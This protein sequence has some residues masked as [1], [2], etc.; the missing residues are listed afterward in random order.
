MSSMSRASSIDIRAF[1]ARG[2]GQHDDTDAIQRS[3]DEASSS[4]GTLVAI[5][6][7]DLAKGEYW[8][9]TR[10]LFLRSGVTIRGEGPESLLYNDRKTSTTFMDQAV[11]LPGNYHPQ[12][13]NSIK[14]DAAEALNASGDILSVSGPTD[15]YNP[16]TI[17]FV[18][19]TDFDPAR[20]EVSIS[21][22]TIIC[23]IKRIHNNEITIDRPVPTDASLVVAPS[24]G[25]VYWRRIGAPSY[26]FVATSSKLLN[27]G[28]RSEGFWIGDSAA[29]ECSFENL[30]IDSRVGIYGNLFQDCIWRNIHLTFDRLAVELSCNSVNVLVENLNARMRTDPPV[31]NHQIIAIQESARNC[32]V[33]NFFIDANVFEKSAPVIRFG[34][35]SVCTILSGEIRC[36]AAK[37]AMVSFDTGVSAVEGNAVRDVSFHCGAALLGIS[38][39]PTRS[40]TVR[41]NRIENVS[42]NGP[43]IQI[44]AKIGGTA[45]TINK[46]KLAGSR[47]V[48]LPSARNCLVSDSTIPSTIDPSGSQTGRVDFLHNRAL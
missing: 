31:P 25:Q 13:L 18:R 23:R 46:S 4:G 8:R 45:N 30:W 1:G 19:T 21:S 28:I 17:I 2:D 29:R 24:N 10:P 16:G 43:R 5:P 20:A 41:N 3:I 35:S 15:R 40:G 39:D 48:I 14:F 38:F 37:G 44:A 47:M 27:L 22:R 7:C 34:P 36:E 9:L 32:T 42:I 26:C 11:I 12:F 6:K 33:R